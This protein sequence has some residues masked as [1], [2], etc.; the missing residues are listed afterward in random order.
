M[1]DATTSL[2]GFT[3]ED[4]VGGPVAGCWH[5]GGFA[6]GAHT[7]WVEPQGDDSDSFVF[8]ALDITLS[9]VDETVTTD[10]SESGGSIPDTGSDTTPLV[11]VASLLLGSGS[12]LLAVRRVRPA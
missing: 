9:C 4:A 3:D 11:L 7:L 8:Q 12:A 1:A 2:A 6:S 10:G 5:L